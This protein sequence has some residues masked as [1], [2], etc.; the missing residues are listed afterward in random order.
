VTRACFAYLVSFDHAAFMGL[1][2]MGRSGAPSRSHAS[3][4]CFVAL[5]LRQE[6]CGEG[7]GMR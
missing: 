4:R 3:M 7:V 6:K 1:S 2:M 5:A